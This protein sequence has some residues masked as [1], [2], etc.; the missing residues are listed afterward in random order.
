LQDGILW[1][2]VTRAMRQHWGVGKNGG[3]GLANFLSGVREA[4]V[5][6]V[7]TEQDDGVVDVG[8]R[9]VPD[10]DVAQVALD[11]GGGGHPQASG[12]TVR[13]DLPQVREL[14]LSEV[15]RSLMAQRAGET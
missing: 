5:V 1:T 14:V 11:L 6:L 3:M 7:F 13:G 4:D 2:E 9:A 8:M 12:C 15:R 10:Y